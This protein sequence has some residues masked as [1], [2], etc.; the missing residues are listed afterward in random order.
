ML[1][2]VNVMDAVPSPDIEMEAIITFV[3]VILEETLP[4][5]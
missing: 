2:Y 5:S 1:P 3:K 4:S